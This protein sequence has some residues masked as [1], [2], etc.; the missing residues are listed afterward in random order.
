MI[1]VQQDFQDRVLEIEAYFDFITRLDTQQ[2]LLVNSDKV[3]P[4]YT[5]AQRDDLHRTLRA[6]AFLLIYNLMESTVSNAV[7]AIFDELQS[8]GVAFDDCS[9]KIR[10][11]VLSN[12]K[13][14]DVKGILP[15]LSV[16]A[17]DVIT[18]TFRKE[19]T[20]SGNVDAQEIRDVAKLYGFDHP[21][22]QQVR[23]LAANRNF[24]SPLVGGRLNDDGSTLVIVK[25][26]RNN[27]AHGSTSFAEV[28]RDFT[29]DGVIQIKCE[30]ISYLEAMLGNVA[31]Y[32]NQQHYRSVVGRP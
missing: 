1:R 23:Q 8:Q 26:R 30:V 25:H 6:S 15:Q 20:F 27:L 9:E 3:T 12:L 10:N 7:E 24:M 29:N 16:L 4:A 21:N 14:L 18:K 2:T 13:K 11:V 17:T 28:G 22:P 19:R 5:M 31:D 32:I